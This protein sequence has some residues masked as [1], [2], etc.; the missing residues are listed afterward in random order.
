MDS[1]AKVYGLKFFWD[2]PTK[3]VTGGHGFDGRVGVVIP[4]IFPHVPC[5]SCSVTQSS[6]P[7]FFRVPQLP[8]WTPH[9]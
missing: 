8:P 7:D 3:D 9:P 6:W 1:S 5:S 4:L 2:S